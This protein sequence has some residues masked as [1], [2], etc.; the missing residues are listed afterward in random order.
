MAKVKSLL[1]L[2]LVR[3]WGN[4]CASVMLV[5]TSITSRATVK[6]NLVAS[7]HEKMKIPVFS[8]PAIFLPIA[9]LK[10]YLTDKRSH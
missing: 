1:F 4:R 3:V 10:K 5:G 6:S 9:V 8:G 2:G 7:T